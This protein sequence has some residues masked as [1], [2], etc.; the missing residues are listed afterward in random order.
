MQTFA[1]ILLKLGRRVGFVEYDDDDS[2]PTLPT[3]AARLH[4]LKEAI[5]D[6]REALYAERGGNW[7]WLRDVERV[8]MSDD[9]TAANCVDSDPGQYLLP[10][11]VAGQDGSSVIVEDE[12]GTSGTRIDLCDVNLVRRRRAQLPDRSGWPEMAAVQRPHSDPSSRLPRC[13]LWVYPNPSEAFVVTVQVRRRFAPLVEMT[14]VELC[15]YP[16]AVVVYGLFAFQQKGAV[17]DAGNA[18]DIASERAE[19]L[20]RL[21][22]EDARSRGRAI[23]QSKKLGLQMTVG[24]VF[25]QYRPVGGTVNGVAT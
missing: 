20:S 14:D 4:R 1:D 24:D 10:A 17:P 25:D 9:G 8:T 19:W 7:H 12:D 11:S 2:T 3:D 13:V 22:D 5:N 15:P 16:E 23:G 21:I 6:G 18:A